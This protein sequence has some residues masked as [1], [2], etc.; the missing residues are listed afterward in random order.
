MHAKAFWP[1]ARGFDRFTGY[2]Q[3]CGSQD[4]HIS[5][6]CG[7]PTNASDFVNYVCPNPAG[8]D[9]RGGD[10]W[11][12]YADS[13]SSANQTSSSELI[14]SLAED[15]IANWTKSEQPFFLYLPFQNIHAPYD[16][17]WESV[18]RFASLDVSI[19][20]KTMF[21]Y[22]YELDVAVGRV[23]AA[24]NAADIL[25]DSLIA[26]VSDNGAPQAEGV[27]DRN[28]PLRGFKSET[29][30]GGT[31]VPAFFFAPGRLPSGRVVDALVSV[32][33]LLPT[34][35]AANGGTPPSNID[36]VNQWPTL[37]GAAPVRNEVVV[38]VNHLCDG[39]QFGNPKAALR[40]GDMKLLCWCFSAKG[41]GGA[42]TTGCTG[43]P[44]YPNDWPQLFN[45][46]ADPSET[47]NLA[48]AQPDVVA[49]LE[50]RLIELAGPGAAA[51]PMQWAPPYQ[52]Q[53]YY[54]RDCPLRNATGPF[55]PWT[56][57]MPDPI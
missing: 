10:W 55:E 22:I 51:E 56:W 17:T 8:K 24:L 20:Q 54:C 15:A 48:S 13:S 50:S 47:T 26:F 40:V 30:E 57:W 4:T 9:Y 3:G 5:S 29:Y 44:A 23:V 7:A 33:D 46:T 21:A 18:Q 19:E 14:A 41:I 6:C 1:Q 52:G 49:A 34:L 25:Q 37:L 53:D 38:N 45:L 2:L 32:T 27:S 28:F 12:G 39:G 43:D 31:R 11:V 35:V 42:N 36:G 16:A